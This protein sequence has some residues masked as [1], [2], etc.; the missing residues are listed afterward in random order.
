MGKFTLMTNSAY[1]DYQGDDEVEIAK[2]VDSETRE[3][4]MYVY[5]D[6]NLYRKSGYH[7]CIDIYE[8]N[9]G[10]GDYAVGKVDDYHRDCL[11]AQPK[12][13]LSMMLHEYGHYI[14]GDLTAE[15][16][17]NESIKAERTRCVAEGRVMEIERKADAF[18][19]SH[20]GK[21]TFMRSMDYLI[22]KRRER[23]DF[24][25]KLAIQEF[26]LRKKEAKKL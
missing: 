2:V 24:A 16:Q 7:I 8:Y 14:N 3:E 26:E 12:V 1:L 6:K 20:V 17:T 4:I 15:G 18:A 19:I 9:D 5:Y 10:S 21:N 11:F 13:F 23:N 25:M 22:K